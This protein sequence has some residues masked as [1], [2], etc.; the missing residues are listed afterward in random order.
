MDQTPMFPVDA[1]FHFGRDFKIIVATGGP[2]GGKITLSR[3]VIDWLKK[4]YGYSVFLLEEIASELFDHGILIDPV[5]HIPNKDFQEKLKIPYQLLKENIWVQGASLS[6]DP[7]KLVWLDRSVLDDEQYAGK[8]LFNRVL[9]SYGLSRMDVRDRR[10]DAVLHF[11]TAAALGSEFYVNNINRTET[12]EKA[13]GRDLLIQHSWVGHRHWRMIPA[14]VNKGDKLELL[15]RHV[16]AILGE[17]E[18]IEIERKFLVEVTDPATL[19]VPNATSTIE[20]MYL[21]P[22]ENGVRSRIRKV[23]C[24]AS[25]MC[26]ETV[27]TLISQGK[28]SEKEKEI[29]L[30]EYLYL[31]GRRDPKRT[32]VKKTRTCFIY[33]HQ[34]FELDNFLKPYTNLAFLEIE[35]LNE[36]DPVDLPPFVK[37]IREV[38]GINTFSNSSLA[39]LSLGPARALTNADLK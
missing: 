35:L 7:K 6:A 24:G 34:Y 10:S 13:L 15:K 39:N 29:S 27:K 11:E 20:Q 3:K 16:L 17:P 21:L 9:S 37:V 5:N 32:K 22:N 23:S 30:Q 25:A 18:P 12:W 2:C 19:L 33:K 38:T 26:F 28:Y 1:R 36:N 31:S 4:D 14:M 8:P